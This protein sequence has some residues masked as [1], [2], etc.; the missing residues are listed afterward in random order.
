MDK[1]LFSCGVFIDLEKAFY[2]ADHKIILH[3]LDHRGFR[4][5]INKWFSSNLQGRTQ[6]TKI[7]SSVSAR[8]DISCGVPRGFVLGPLLFLIYINDIQ[9]CS[10]ELIFFSFC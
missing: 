10:E 2:T 7:D 8:N 5:V 6:K 3:K 1:R 9:E 4:C